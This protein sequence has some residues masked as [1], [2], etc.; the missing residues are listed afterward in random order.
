MLLLNDFSYVGELA[1]G[2]V[3]SQQ[4]FKTELVQ[5]SLYDGIL[6]VINPQRPAITQKHAPHKLEM[7]DK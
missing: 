6:A 1:D 7:I 2:G 4:V 3:D 5:L